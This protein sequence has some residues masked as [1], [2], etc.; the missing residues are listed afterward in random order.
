MLLILQYMSSCT[1][2]VQVNPPQTKLVT[3]S[4]FNNN[5]S[6]TSAQTA[7]Y[8]LMVNNAESYNMALYTGLL[9]DELTNYNNS[10]SQ[11]FLQF[12]TNSLTALQTP[13]PWANIYNYIY[14]ANAVLA[15]MQN[16]SNITPAVSQQ[17]SGEAKFTRAF[18]YFY[19][20]NLYGDVPLVLTTDYSVNATMARTAKNI[21]YQQI[22]ADL[23]DAQ[24]MLSS[25]F[26]DASDT[27]ITTERTRPTKWAAAALLARAYLFTGDYADAETQASSVI[28][29]SMFSLCPNL[30]SVFLANSTEAIWQMAIPLPTSNNTYDGYY[31]ILISAPG[32]SGPC[33]SISN[34]LLNSFEPGD[35]R[36]TN[37]IDSF[38]TTTVPI[39]SYFYPYKYRVRTGATVSEYQMVFRLGELYLVRAEA[40]AQLGETSGAI[41]DLNAIRTRAKLN[42]YSGFSDKG[43]LL[44]AIL[45]E[46]QVELFTEWGTRWF[47]LART[48]IA[49]SVMTQVEPHKGGAWDGS[50][51][52]LLYPIPQTERNVDPNL[53]QNSGY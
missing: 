11:T 3:A 17:L 1:K 26:L 47:D 14:Q 32:N 13:G 9:G 41:S 39:V 33:C 53:S 42:N 29:N 52:Q 20:A 36:R 16:N 5:A 28:A 25:N 30:T 35:A 2:F 37:W 15:A 18:W 48:G 34:Q 24:N 27:A 23:K 45:H 43:S 50:G 10:T 19:L 49:D 8:S 31:F 51:Y 12:Y 21:I 7:I 22:I 6:A 4:V 40:R 44:T 46:R 38:K